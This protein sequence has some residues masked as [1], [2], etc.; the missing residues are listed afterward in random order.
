MKKSIPIV[1]LLLL[2]SAALARPVKAQATTITIDPAII[3]DKYPG[4]TFTVDITIDIGTNELFMW[5]LS[6][7]W[8]P[9]ILDLTLDPIEGPFVKDQVGS[10]VFV[11]TLIGDGFIDSLT[12]GSM[13]GQVATGSGVIAVLNFTALEEGDSVLDLYAPDDAAQTES[14]IWLTIGGVESAFDTVNDGAVN[15]IPEF[16]V[17]LILPL[18]MMMTLVMVLIT[19]WSKKRRHHLIVQ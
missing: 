3:T 1:I 18:F 7:S 13:T 16:L 2:T 11:W 4:D 14:P 9:V 8:D 15:V 17:F 10:T 12:C 19:I 6:I 5:V